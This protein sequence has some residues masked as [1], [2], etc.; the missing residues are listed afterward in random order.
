MLRA[1]VNFLGAFIPHTPR[2]DPTE[3]M[4]AL[5]VISEADLPA[6]P[7]AQIAVYLVSRKAP[8]ANDNTEKDAHHMVF[9]DFL[10]GSQTKVENPEGTIRG[11]AFHL[12]ADTTGGP[13][14]GE[15]QFERRDKSECLNSRCHRS[16]RVGIL[17]AANFTALR[18]FDGK[19]VQVVD[20]TE[21]LIAIMDLLHE[22]RIVGARAVRTLMEKGQTR[23]WSSAVNCQTF[24]KEFITRLGLPYPSEFA[25]S[26]D[27]VPAMIKDFFFFQWNANT[28]AFGETSFQAMQ[29]KQI[30]H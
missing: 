27:Y 19:S 13:N 24:A 9:V 14:D 2:L 1:I 18:N 20:T 30:D 10:G 4:S 3:S 25:G 8:L 17:T 26:S 16:V 29:N 15:V 5:L 7:V 12:I 23:K 21:R 28:R 6:V 11:S 22:M